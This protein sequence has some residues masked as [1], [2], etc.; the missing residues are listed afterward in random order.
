V[1]PQ[2]II[3][4]PLV[5][6]KGR[7]YSLELRPSTGRV[8]YKPITAIAADAPVRLT[9][10][11]HGVPAG[12]IVAAIGPAG[13]SPLLQAAGPQQGQFATVIDADTL[14]L[15]AIASLGWAAYVGGAVLVYNEPRDLS[16]LTPVLA[17]YPKA[18]NAAA[19]FTLAV[20]SGLAVSASGLIASFTAAQT[21]QIPREGAVYA[22]SYSEGGQPQLFAC[23]AI[24]LLIVEGV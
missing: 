22:I 11:A 5:L 15:N 4:T 18:E 13:V 9:V 7:A 17:V 14:E 19:L 16:A 12:W 2:P 8:I 21:A 24:E 20:G 3:Q 1:I 6:P 23:G 10:P